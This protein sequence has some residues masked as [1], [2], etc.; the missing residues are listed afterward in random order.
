VE[1]ESKH[2]PRSTALTS[3]CPALAMSFNGL[4]ALYIAQTLGLVAGNDGKI[5]AG[6]AKELDEVRLSFS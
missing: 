5:E 2:S 1:L 4:T 6:S 3:I